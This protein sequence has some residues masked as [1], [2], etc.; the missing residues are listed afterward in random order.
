MLY[1]VEP[2]EQT[3]DFKQWIFPKPK[4]LLGLNN[5]LLVV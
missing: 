1:M 4:A 2:K 3:P 5:V